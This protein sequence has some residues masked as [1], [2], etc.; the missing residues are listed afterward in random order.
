MAL[1]GQA[2]QTRLES[3]VFSSG[4]LGK[5]DIP[6]SAFWLDFSEEL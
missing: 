5:E 3:P 1:E 2:G 4:G 6:I